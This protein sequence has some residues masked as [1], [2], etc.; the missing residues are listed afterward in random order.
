M[1]RAG[2]ALGTVCVADVQEACEL[3]VFGQVER[4]F[5]VRRV[6]ASGPEGVEPEVGGFHH[7]GR[8]D[9]ACVHVAAVVLVVVVRGAVALF[10]VVADHE[11]HGGV[12]GHARNAA[13]LFEGLG[14]LDYENLDG[15]HVFG[16]GS[17]TAG[18]QNL[19]EFFRF[20]R[21]GGK[22]A[23]AV[24]GLDKIDKRHNEL[25]SALNI[26]NFKFNHR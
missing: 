5:D 17:Q 14:G 15:L 12:I 6:E 9:N 18:L 22:C 21:F 4:T 11:H 23:T 13:E 2:T 3:D 26:N 7:H 10:F 20:H 25:L 19:L 16:S 8:R 1:A 24:A